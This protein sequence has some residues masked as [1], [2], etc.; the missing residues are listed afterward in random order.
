MLPEFISFIRDYYQRPEGPIP[1]HESLIGETEQLA[2]RDCLESGI[3]SSV[4]PQVED[5]EQQI[6]KLTACKFAVATNSGT[7]ALHLALLASGVQKDDLVITQPFSFVASANAISYT[8]ASPLFLDISRKSLG[9]S[10]DQLAD[11]LHSQSELRQD[12]CSWHKKTGRR[13]AACL[14]V[15]SFGH[16]PAMEEIAAI[17]QEHHII[18]IEDAAEALGST[19]KGHS[20]GHWGKVAILSFNGNKIISCGGGGMLLTHDAALARQALHLSQQARVLRGKQIAYDQVGYNYRMP[21]LNASLGLAQLSSLEERKAAL[22]MQQRAYQQFFAGYDLPL[23]SEAAGTHANYWLHAVAF[24]EKQQR[25][26]FV[27][28]TQQEGIL[29]RPGWALLSDMPMF[30][31]CTKAP[32]PNARW[33]SDHLALLPSSFRQ[34]K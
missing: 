19:C 11:F 13:I 5:F 7:A 21:N 9:L 12:G 16:P 1:L 30:S 4:G 17:C 28:M 24:P 23:I 10:A 15:Y 31:K 6:G 20:P 3:I 32:L 25:D 22:R 29:T 8:G 33:A 26:E 14:P 18:L 27:A 2:M 34:W